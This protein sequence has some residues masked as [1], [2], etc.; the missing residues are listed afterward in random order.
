MQPC[1]RVGVQKSTLEKG[2]GRGHLTQAYAIR[3]L[4]LRAT[5]LLNYNSRGAQVIFRLGGADMEQKA[6]FDAAAGA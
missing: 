5:P 3:L 2:T 6:R 1:D 4:L